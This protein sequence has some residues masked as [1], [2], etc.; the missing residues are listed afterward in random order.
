MVY[1]VHQALLDS[2]ACVNPNKKAITERGLN[3]LMFNCPP[4]PEILA[5][6]NK[7]VATN[8]ARTGEQQ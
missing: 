5:P 1:L 4:H 7:G 3:P 6:N 8:G 2:F